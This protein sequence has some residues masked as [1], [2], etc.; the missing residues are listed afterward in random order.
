MDSFRKHILGMPGL[1]GL[2]AITSFLMVFL[3]SGPGRFFN[4]LGDGDS[5]WLIRT[6]EWILQH[7]LP[8]T[9]P[10][11]NGV[12]ALEIPLVSYQWLFEVL[13]G[14]AHQWVGL[15]GV[16]LL[17]AAGFSLSILLLTLYLFERGFKAGPDIL[18]SILLSLLVLSNLAIARPAL[19]TLLLTAA[20]LWIWHKNF[21]ARTCWCL[22]LP[23]FALWSNLHLGFFA[24]LIILAVLCA[25]KALATRSNWPWWLLA[26]ALAAT[27]LNPYGLTLWS[28]FQMLGG[29]HF[30]NAAITELR[31]PNFHDQ[32]VL[33]VFVLLEILAA[34]IAFHHRRIQSSDRI[35][36]VLS[37]GCT[38][39]SGRHAYLL[40]IFGLP[41]LA[42][43]L[44]GAQSWLRPL[45]LNSF[46]LEQEKPWL[47]LLGI[48][49]VGMLLARTGLLP[50]EFPQARNLRGV[51]SELKQLPSN[52]PVLTNEVWGSYLIY[53]SNTRSVIDT[54]MDMY[55]DATVQKWSNTLNL[56][57][58]WQKNLDASGVD[59]L[60]YP[61]QAWQREWLVG[62]G[63][64]RVHY[65]DA[66]AVMLERER[67]LT[68]MPTP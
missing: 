3:T 26:T 12:P 57:P 25:E 22:L 29:S 21:S 63:N 13:L 51:L 2:L 58:G 15:G 61:A 23:L 30:M 37:L 65:Q 53:Y 28:Y 38:L 14:L 54:R 62:T 5:C 36:F 40:A 45:Q 48:V 67:P 59:T 18:F 27:F 55:G 66:T 49:G 31:S 16:L 35:L 60:I 39:Y 19:A 42:G 52:H 46:T 24:G 4:V 64:W 17:V 10:F 68:T 7:G 33:L 11:S 50:V 32:P 56:Q 6:G 44:E 43:A 47:W 41:F 34:M 1:S 8:A 20:L 9:N